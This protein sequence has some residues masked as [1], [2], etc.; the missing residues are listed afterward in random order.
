MILI[1]CILIITGIFFGDLKIKNLIEQN[2][3]KDTASPETASQPIAPLPESLWNNRILVKKYHNKG[4]MLN[5]GQHRSSAVAAL[6]VILCILMTAAFLASF[7]TRGNNLLR[8]GL[9]FLLGGSFSNTYDRLKRKYVVDYF[10]FNVKYR[11]LRRIVF[12]ISDF[13]I[14]I[15]ALL[16]VLGTP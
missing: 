1:C 16:A 2:G 14:M 10:S 9:S 6:S 15:G 8:I 7:C 13:C 12:N 5:L 4:A 3:K 11:G